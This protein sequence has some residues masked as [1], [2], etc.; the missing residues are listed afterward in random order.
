MSPEEIENYAAAA[1]MNTT[2]PQ[3]L[4]FLDSI[5]HANRKAYN[6]SQRPTQPDAELT[7]TI[8]WGH[9]AIDAYATQALD[10]ATDPREIGF[11]STVRQ[12]AREHISLL[13]HRDRPI[14]DAADAVAAVA[15]HADALLSQLQAGWLWKILTIIPTP[16]DPSCPTNA[17]PTKNDEPCRRTTTNEQ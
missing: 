4:E 9:A 5:R 13:A 3:E 12:I 11:L 14:P 16:K 7:A 10:K 2:D 17:T 1:T 15:A 6:A 8:P